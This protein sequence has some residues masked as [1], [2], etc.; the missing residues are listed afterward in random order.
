MSAAI[1][2]VVGRLIPPIYLL[3]P[4]PPFFSVGGLVVDAHLGLQAPKNL[5]ESF[6][7]TG[8]DPIDDD[9]RW[10][11]R[12]SSDT[13]FVFPAVQR[14]FGSIPHVVP[15]LFSFLCTSSPTHSH[16]HTH[17]LSLFLSFFRT[18]GSFGRHNR[19]HIV[20]GWAGPPCVSKRFGRSV[21]F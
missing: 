14:T 1:C 20:N 7:S 11:N 19:R 13:R 9:D 6:F 8:S 10:I 3:S 21:A 12:V 4:A 2:P 18:V 5:I 17:S 15:A 16:T